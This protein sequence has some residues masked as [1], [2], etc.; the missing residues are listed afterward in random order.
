MGFLA[1]RISI[2]FHFGP[3]FSGLTRVLLPGAEAAL[4][5]LYVSIIPEPASGTL[6]VLGLLG[7]RFLRQPLR[8]GSKSSNPPVKD[9]QIPPSTPPP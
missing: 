5:N 3:E 7:I 6:L 2:L 8:T 9:T 4:D 1:A